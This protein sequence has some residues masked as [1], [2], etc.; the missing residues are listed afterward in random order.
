MLC[1][2]TADTVREIKDNG[3]PI[4]VATLFPQYDFLREIVKD[5]ADVYLL[6]PPG[7]ESHSYE[8]G[9]ADIINIS[10]SDLFVYAGGNVDIWAE[11][12]LESA[13]ISSTRTIALTDTVPLLCEEHEG[14]DH[15]NHEEHHGHSEY[16]EHVWTSPANAIR[17]CRALCEEICIADEKN[18][19]FYIS[20]CDE[21]IAKL[22]K[23]DQAAR[24]T[25]ENAKHNTL[26][27]ADRFPIR[28][29]T[30]EYGLEYI[31]AFPGCAAETEPGPRTL[32]KLIDKV[33]EDDIPAVF[34]RE[35]SNQK[36]ADLVC[37]STKAKKLLFHSCHN[38]SAED[39]EKGENY[40]SIMTK[41][42]NNLKEA[43]Y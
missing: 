33:R 29:F 5:R 28:Y 15:D 6:I 8:P 32:V 26:V 3:K 37:E 34:Y 31:A 43:L 41:N 2:C 19:E 24:E 21:Y 25:V 42:I 17:I 18:K 40:I 13:D 35:F 39:F 20:N 10:K 12:L 16:D 36:V 38:L 1:S 23:L 7:G 14:H 27:F 9:P 4:I 30:E 11:R 22:E